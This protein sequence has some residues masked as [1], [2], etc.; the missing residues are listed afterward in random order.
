M[1]THVMQMVQ[2]PDQVAHKALGR[3]LDFEMALRRYC[4]EQVVV[5]VSEM[6]MLFLLPSLFKV[7]VSEM[8]M[9]RRR[10]AP[11]MGL[12]SGMTFSSITSKAWELLI[13]IPDKNSLRERR[14]VE[15]TMLRH[16]VAGWD[17]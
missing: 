17:C 13:N 11:A 10:L 15:S 1:I 3:E 14:K 4:Q 5:S 8:I 7:L 6:T 2:D 9:R 16:L 12:A